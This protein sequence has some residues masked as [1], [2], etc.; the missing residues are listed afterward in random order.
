MKRLPLVGLGAFSFL[1]GSA[2]ILLGTPPVSDSTQICTN[3]ICKL[4]NDELYCA[5]R[6]NYLCSMADPDHC[7]ANACSGT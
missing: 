7:S 1:I 6:S 4:E 2:T 5:F 3:T